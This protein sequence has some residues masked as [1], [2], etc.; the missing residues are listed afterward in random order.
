MA[1]L[2]GGPDAPGQQGDLFSQAGLQV[3]EVAS[4]TGKAGALFDRFGIPPFTVFDARTGAWRQRKQRWLAL[5]I[6]SEDGRFSDVGGTY[7]SRPAGDAE[8]LPG[9]SRNVLE[10]YNGKRPDPALL[11]G[12]AD[13]INGAKYGNTAKER[14][15]DSGISIFDPVLCEAIYRWYTTPGD[16]VLDPFAGGSVRGVVAGWLGRAYLG[17]DIRTGQVDANYRQADTIFAGSGKVKPA[18]V[19]G[20]STNL[21]RILQHAAE[22]AGEE[23]LRPDLVFTCPPYYDLEVYSRHDGD[24]SALDSYPEFLSWYSYIFSQAVQL[25]KDDR[26]L[27][28]VVGDVRDR[29]T[30]VLRD[31]PGDSLRILRGLGLHLLN[32]AIL[33]TAAG[34]LPVRTSAHFAKNRKLGRTHQLV[35]IL[36]KGDPEAAVRRLG[37][38]VEFG[39]ADAAAGWEGAGT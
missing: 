29:Q 16:V 22:M 36:V 2:I 38:V 21:R 25:L 5:G 23:L 4:A 30:G 10:R 8:A 1:K 27:V 39:G 31:F 19:A 24:G 20:D 11:A 14:P 34:S 13:I 9:G 6:T 17:V 12:G 3:G 35:H 28:V 32:D 37:Q 7:A 18:W 26:F 33:L 15:T